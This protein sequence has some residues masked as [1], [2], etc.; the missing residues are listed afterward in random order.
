MQKI[1]HR[2]LYNAGLKY[3]ELNDTTKLILKP[4]IAGDDKATDFEDCLKTDANVSRQI[5]LDANLQLKNG[6]VQSI[7][8]AVVLIGKNRVRDFIFSNCILTCT[9]KDQDSIFQRL[10][11]EKNFLKHAEETDA[12]TRKM[13]CD[14]SGGA[15]VA[16]FLFDF[17][18]NL[19][20]HKDLKK[21]F[22]SQF[23]EA[24]AHGIRT[25]AMA[26]SFA[27]ISKLS[28]SL[29]RQAFLAGLSHDLGRILMWLVFPNESAK[30]LEEFARV[31]LS[32]QWH[33]TSEIE[34]E[35]KYLNL[36]HCEIGSMLLIA[37]EFM[38]EVE[39]VVAFHHDIE[40]LKLRS[41][42]VL[43]IAQCVNLADDL[44][45]RMQGKMRLTD[46]QIGL[47]LKSLNNPLNIQASSIAGAIESLIIKQVFS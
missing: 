8:H 31:K 28:N 30:I 35:K 3:F 36:T 12:T 42:K 29:C 33:N 21:M 45:E 11:K 47:S 26:W 18:D 5:I 9:M 40:M 2:E 27:N 14:F 41:S 4:I 37:T 38:S 10:L 22:E 20:I 16:G 46:E 43:Q 25:A 17:L 24:Y 13:G 1:I 15:W 39:E 23:K 19:L 6:S 32:N 44:V 7:S 34:I